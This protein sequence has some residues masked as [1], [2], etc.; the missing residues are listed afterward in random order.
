MRRLFVA[1]L[2]VLLLVPV[3]WSQQYEFITPS[4]PGMSV[5]SVN[6]VNNHGMIVGTYVDANQHSHALL[7]KDGQ[8]LP[9]GPNTVLQSNESTAWGLNERGDIVGVY[10]ENGYMMP[11]FHGFVL[12]K[13][14]RFATLDFPTADA[15]SAFDIND[16][17]TVVGMWYRSAQPGTGRRF[18]FMHGFTWKNGNFTEIWKPGS[19]DTFAEG[20]NARGDI[21]GMTETDPT[22]METTGFIYSHGEFSDFTVQLPGAIGVQ[23]GHINEKGQIAGGYWNQ[24]FEVRGFIRTGNIYTDVMVPASAFTA[25][26]AIN[27]SGVIAGYYYDA[28]Y[29]QLGFVGIPKK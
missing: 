2:F 17:G 3:L 28:N 27:N 8:C 23:P 15:S 4:C 9:L 26:M 19:G 25:V 1:V 20:I 18:Q 12:Y 21:C 22:A 29:N 13:D 11:P 7:I 5:V 16:S 6:D 10:F 24:Y 14:G